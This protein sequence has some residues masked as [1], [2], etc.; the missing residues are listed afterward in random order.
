MV[1]S[2]EQILAAVHLHV[3]VGILETPRPRARKPEVLAAAAVSAELEPEKTALVDRL[4]HD[5]AGTV[6]EEDERRPVVPV[7]DLRQDVAAHDQRPPRQAR[8][9]HGVRLRDGIDE[10]RTTPEQA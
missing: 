3:G 4:H 7:E 2:A 9:E 5:R 10:P 6:A 8:R 1:Y